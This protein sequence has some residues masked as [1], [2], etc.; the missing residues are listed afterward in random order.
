MV[1]FL[2][3]VSLSLSE[4]D[5]DESDSDSEDEDEDDEAEE[6]ETAAAFSSLVCLEALASFLLPFT[7]VVL[8]ILYYPVRG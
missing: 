4:E 3:S 2:V 8:A 7:L 6:E 5:E 1:S